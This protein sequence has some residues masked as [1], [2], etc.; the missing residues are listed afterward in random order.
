MNG[1]NDVDI[2]LLIIRGIWTELMDAKQRG[3]PWLEHLKELAKTAV[4]LYTSCARSTQA[5]TQ[6][7]TR[8]TQTQTRTYA[9]PGEVVVRLEGSPF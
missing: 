3:E 5:Q 2:E 6:P 8:S 7:G 4:L 9:Q 1:P